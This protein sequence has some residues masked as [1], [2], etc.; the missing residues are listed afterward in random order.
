MVAGTPAF[1][2]PS[3]RSFAL[4][5][6][7]LEDRRRDPSGT[8]RLYP[9]KIWHWL[10]PY[11]TLSWGVPIVVS[12]GLLYSALYAAAAAGMAAA[13]RRGVAGFCLAV[14]AISMAAHV[15]ILVLWRYRVP[16]WDPILLLYAVPGASRFLPAERLA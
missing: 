14:L 4:L 8:A 2:S 13:Q 16:F 5:R 15:L 7:A 12:A 3:R 9:R 6:A 1:E 10:R 11:P